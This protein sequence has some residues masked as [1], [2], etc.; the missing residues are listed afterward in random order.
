MKP[1]LALAF[2]AELASV[3]CSTVGSSYN[4]LRPGDVESKVAKIMGDCPNGSA[5]S[6]VYRGIT[7][8]SRSLYFMQF[9]PSTYSFIFQN[10]G[11]L[12]YGEGNVI[13]TTIDNE[14]ALD[15][16]PLS[17]KTPTWLDWAPAPSP[18]KSAEP[19]K[20][21]IPNPVELAQLSNSCR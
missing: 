12:K 7:Y 2:I 3:S 18:A 15:I 13:R 5:S 4:R 17:Q 14:P 10:G 6:G 11:L 9:A 19:D 20:K 8:T 21:Q 1:A 16:S